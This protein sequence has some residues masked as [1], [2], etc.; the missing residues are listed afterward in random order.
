MPYNLML[1]LICFSG[2]AEMTTKKDVPVTNSID[3]S[4]GKHDT[5]EV[6]IHQDTNITTV[7]QRK[8]ERRDLSKV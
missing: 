3:I 5:N 1:S 4:V 6:V 7:I 2:T 8:I